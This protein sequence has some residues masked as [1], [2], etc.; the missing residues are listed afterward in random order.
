MPRNMVKETSED[1][2][3]CTARTVF[4]RGGV[5]VDPGNMCGADNDTERA[6]GYRHRGASG[7]VKVSA[8]EWKRGSS[9]PVKD[10]RNEWTLT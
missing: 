8:V 5:E 9:T 2:S 6:E 3:T 10:V 4:E 1:P 7:R